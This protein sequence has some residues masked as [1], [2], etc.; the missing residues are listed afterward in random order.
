MIQFNFLN[1]EGFG[2]FSTPIEFN[3][4]NVGVNLIKGDNGV[5]KTTLFSA[6]YWCLFG[7]SLKNVKASQMVTWKKLRKNNWRGT[8]VVLNVTINGTVY[9]ITRHLGFKGTTKGKEQE[10][11]V[12]V[13]EYVGNGFNA[14]NIKGVANTQNYINNI[15]GMNSNTF[16]NSVLFG[17][18]LKKLLMASG[19]DKRTL[20]EE[21]FELSFIQKAKDLALNDLKDITDKLNLV[22]TNIQVTEAKLSSTKDHLKELTKVVLNFDREKEDEINIL[23]DNVKK[24]TNRISFLKDNIYN[25]KQDLQKIDLKPLNELKS[26]L[27]KKLSSWI[28]QVKSSKKKIDNIKS[29]SVGDSCEC[30]GREF[31]ELHIKEVKITHN[32]TIKKENKVIKTGEISIAELNEDLNVVNKDIEKALSINKKYDNHIGR[33]N[34]YTTELDM[35]NKQL[36]SL[37][38]RITK[39]SNRQLAEYDLDVYKETIKELS[40][41]LENFE[42]TKHRLEQ[43]INVVSFWSKVG[44]G[45]N[46]LKSYMFNAMLQD[47]NNYV[48]YYSKK[49]GVYVSFGVDMSKKS[50]PF[51]TTC[52]VNGH[53][54]DYE[55]LSGGQQQ[56]VDLVVA[57][58]L[59]DFVSS[60]VNVNIL[61]MDEPFQDLDEKGIELLM[62]LISDKKDKSIYIISHKNI[63]VLNG[64]VFNIKNNEIL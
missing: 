5:G 59:H 12:I 58:A 63:T 28:F 3:L 45:S 43:E 16:I 52:K 15:L 11:G 56:R 44:F 42:S 18:R 53:I 1:I 50:R 35:L 22:T 30:C 14:L 13:F 2:S 64:R 26:A 8:R 47:V 6:L 40:L 7:K 38:E 37:K 24:V 27:T 57:M 41:K 55:E 34:S 51:K 4:D 32:N 29:I 49:L 10:D 60:N 33:L 20:F 54:A 46:G 31:D 21:V 48:D 17:Q 25:S 62:S 23:N 39:T 61:V 36:V 9:L 19:A